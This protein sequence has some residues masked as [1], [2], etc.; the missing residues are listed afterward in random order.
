MREIVMERS[1]EQAAG[2]E[3]V[4]KSPA[5][6]LEESE[7]ETFYR[8]NARPLWGFIY[9]TVGDPA[10]ADEILQ[11]AFYQFLRAADANAPDVQL[12]S[13]VYRIAT[14]LMSDHWRR[15][16]KS[17]FARL[18]GEADEESWV[19]HEPAE[20]LNMRHDV[21][22]LFKRLKPQERALLWLAHVEGAAHGEIASAIGVKE[23]SVKVLLFRARRRFAAILEKSGIIDGVGK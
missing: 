12:R 19:D 4:A 17:P 15:G 3:P 11:S 5:R 7:F 1:V 23:K 6:P 14:N 9:R 18:E 21:G 13:F 22:R 20:R 2:S 16:R 8:K 10:L